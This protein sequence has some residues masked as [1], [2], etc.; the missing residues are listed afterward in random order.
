MRIK[1]ILLQ[2]GAR[3]DKNDNQ[4][5]SQVLFSSLDG[6]HVLEKVQRENI[7]WIGV[8]EIEYQLNHSN[9]DTP[10]PSSLGGESPR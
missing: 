4:T 3:R 8:G 5:K 2:R 7:N 9:I 1:I 6:S 10:W